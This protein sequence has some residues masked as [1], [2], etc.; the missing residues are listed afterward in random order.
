MPDPVLVF[1][2]EE[3]MVFLSI[4]TLVIPSDSPPNPVELGT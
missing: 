3:L 1:F 2:L 4:E